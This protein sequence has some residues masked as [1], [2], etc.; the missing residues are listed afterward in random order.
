MEIGIRAL[1]RSLQIADPLRP[2]ERNWGSILGEIRKGIEAKW[3]T[4]ATRLTGDGNLFDE[5][6]ASLDAV[7]NPWRNSTMH[8]ERKYTEEEAEHIFST[9][10][11]F[12]IRLSA[13]MDENGKPLA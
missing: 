13:R 1:A 7:K 10:R 6:H 9:V 11:G 5:L 8:V 2:A 3:P 4:A 12:M